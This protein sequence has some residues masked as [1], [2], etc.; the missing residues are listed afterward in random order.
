MIT[1]SFNFVYDCG[2]FKSEKCLKN[3]INK[4]EKDILKNDTIDLLIISHFDSDHFNGLKYLLEENISQVKIILP[5]CTKEERYAY[6]LLYIQESGEHKF[7][8]NTD[9][10][11]FVIDPVRYLFKKYY[12]KIDKVILVCPHCTKCSSSDKEQKKENHDHK[13]PAPRYFDNKETMYVGVDYQFSFFNVG[14]GLFYTG[15]IEIDEY[16]YYD[17][18]EYFIFEIDEYTTGVFSEH[19]L[20]NVKMEYNELLAQGKYRDKIITINVEQNAVALGIWWFKFFNLNMEIPAFI[21]ADIKKATQYHSKKKLLGKFET[22]VKNLKGEKIEFNNTSLV[23][24]HKPYYDN[25]RIKINNVKNSIVC[26]KCIECSTCA[27]E[28]LM[29]SGNDDKHYLKKGENKTY[30]NEIE[31]DGIIVSHLLTGDL[32]L[33]NGKYFNEYEKYFS[34]ELETISLAAIPHHG[35]EN[36]SDDKFIKS[37]NT[38]SYFISSSSIMKRFDKYYP[39]KSIAEKVQNKLYW[40]SETTRVINKGKMKIKYEKNNILESREF[41][42]LNEYHQRLLMEDDGK[43]NY[44]KEKG[45]SIDI[46]ED[47]L[48]GLYEDGEIQYDIFPYFDF[49]SRLIAYK[50]L[51][52][53]K[54]YRES[55]F[56]NTYGKVFPLYGMQYLKYNDR[57]QDLL[58]CEGEKDFLNLKRLHYQCL[59]VYSATKL[60]GLTKLKEYF[61]QSE[62]CNKII[63]V[64]DNDYAGKNAMKSKFLKDIRLPNAYYIEYEKIQNDTIRKSN[65][66]TDIVSSLKKDDMN[67]DVR[68]VLDKYLFNKDVLIKI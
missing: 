33:R 15:K 54:K 45:I 56:W 48:I 63:F 4:Y 34:N 57:N 22:I 13:L 41:K 58:I 50:A 62:Y 49:N 26:E 37:L 51:T 43:I 21:T 44:W 30:N 14:H 42:K 19:C 52:R 5:Y 7:E 59:S 46:L 35:S 18:K 2:S 17:N 38:S 9:Y 39:N 64:F 6:A 25:I 16:Y 10:I 67:V 23:V 24:L 47:N 3:S 32:N 61:D 12:K 1:K 40:S 55:S 20:N 36:S 28:Q 66:I 68:S 31:D 60:E 53:E 65:D 29:N 11:D 8:I 27:I